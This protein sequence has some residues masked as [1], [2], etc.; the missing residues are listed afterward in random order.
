MCTDGTWT[1]K[2]GK[3]PA[4]YVTI[5]HGFYSNSSGKH[6]SIS[7]MGITQFKKFSLLPYGDCSWALDGVVSTEAALRRLWQ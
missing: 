6:C 1:Y 2:G 4:S 5:K 7:K 3:G